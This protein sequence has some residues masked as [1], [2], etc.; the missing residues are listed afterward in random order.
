MVS[1]TGT[2]ED[3]LARAAAAED[4]EKSKLS[5]ARIDKY[6][7]KRALLERYDYMVDV[8]AGPGG[9]RPNEE[10]FV[11]G[12]DRCGAEF[13]VKGV[14]NEVSSSISTSCIDLMRFIGTQADRRACA[15][16]YGRLVTEKLG[17]IKERVFSCCPSPGAVTCQLGPHVFRVSTSIPLAGPS[18]TRLEVQDKSIEALHSRIPFIHTSSLSSFR[19]P[20]IPPHDIVALDCE[21]VYTTSGMALARL[22]VVDSSGLVILDAHVRP[23][24]SVLDLNTRFSG[25]KQSDVEMAVLDVVGV[26]EELGKLVG[27]NTIIVGHGLENDLK[28]LRIVHLTVVDTAI[29]SPPDSIRFELY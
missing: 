20:T 2:L 11:T 19:S 1:E 9:T 26:R 10:G 13:M 25:V 17:G 3:D 5:R 21:L 14:L 28:A 6:V 15:Y 18:L 29:V 22:T 27:V 8:P 12:C 23:H 4:A 16:H 24:G 7:S